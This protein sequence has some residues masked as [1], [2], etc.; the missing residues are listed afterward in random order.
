MKTIVDAALRAEAVSCRLRYR[1]QDCVH[2][3]EPTKLCAEGFPNGGHRE[4]RI[5]EACVI[6]FCKSF[7]LSG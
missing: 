2:F 3:D 5:E 6:E 4:Q 7:E 1:C